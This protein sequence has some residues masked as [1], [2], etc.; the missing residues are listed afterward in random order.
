MKTVNMILTKN[1]DGIIYK[2]LVASS[3]SLIKTKDGKTLTKVLNEIKDALDNVYTKK[4]IED[5][6]SEITGGKAVLTE[7]AVNN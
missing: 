6:I 5:M 1:I 7:D 4:E 3:P 2:L